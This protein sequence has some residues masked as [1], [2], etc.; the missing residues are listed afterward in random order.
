MSN[1]RLYS[2]GSSFTHTTAKVNSLLPKPTTIQK[3]KISNK[4]KITAVRY[5]YFRYTILQQLSFY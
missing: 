4:L 1:T 2:F 5:N 3:Y